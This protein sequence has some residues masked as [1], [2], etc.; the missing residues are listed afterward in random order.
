MRNE[1]TM[2]FFHCWWQGEFSAGCLWLHLLQVL[3]L[4]HCPHTPGARGCGHIPAARTSSGPIFACPYTQWVGPG[5]ADM[6]MAAL[7]HWS[8]AINLLRVMWT[9]QILPSI[10]SHSTAADS[11][12]SMN[13][14][15]GRRQEIGSSLVEKKNEP[16][17]AHKKLTVV[18]QHT[19]LA[20]TWVLKGDS[21]N[22]DSDM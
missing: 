11:R 18:S 13:V 4:P 2:I 6:S 19:L 22:K 5:S 3:S 21:M 16:L 9:L 10:Y 14:S 8:Q 7:T 12:G 1:S 15:G 20:S 17:D